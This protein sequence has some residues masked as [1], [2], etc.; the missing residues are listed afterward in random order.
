MPLRTC[1]NIRCCTLTLNLVMLFWMTKAMLYSLISVCQSNMT[2]MANLNPLP[3][4]VEVRLAMHLWNKP[5][6]GK[7]SL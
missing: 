4:L 2:R 3:L 1:M 5:I 7:R 6:I